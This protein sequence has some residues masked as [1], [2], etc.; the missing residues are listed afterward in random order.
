MEAHKLIYGS[1]STKLT[2]SPNTKVNGKANGKDDDKKL[3]ASGIPTF[4]KD[5]ALS[6]NSKV[7]GGRNHNN[8][9]DKIGGIV[10]VP[11]RSSHAY[12]RAATIAPPGGNPEYYAVA[13]WLEPDDGSQRSLWQCKIF[14][15]EIKRNA[16]WVKDLGIYERNYRLF[17]GNKIVNNAKGF[18]VRVYL[19]FTPQPLSID[20]VKQF[21][22]CIADHINRSPETNDGQMVKVRVT[23]D[24]RNFIIP[25]HTNTVW[26]TVLGDMQ[27]FKHLCF[28]DGSMTGPDWGRNNISIAKTYFTEGDVPL[29]LARELGLPNSWVKPDLVAL[30]A[31]EQLSGDDSESDHA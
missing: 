7:T 10:P 18:A 27:A 12:I 30:S 13:F 8:Q 24:F 9:E 17:I 2:M 26:S 11:S 20:E 15:D 14:L 4:L 25:G 21:A 22:K 28:F 1:A 6:T 31:N 16:P 23:D 5:I 19:R 3:A 29:D